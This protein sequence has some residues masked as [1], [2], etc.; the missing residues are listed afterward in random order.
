[1][2]LTE[3]A[4][5]HD[6]HDIVASLRATF[7]DAVDAGAVTSAVEAALARYESARVR[8]FVPLL[9]ERYVRARLREQRTDEG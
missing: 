7:V 5:E 4:F 8:D 3:Q 1:M 9:V 6:I 2:T